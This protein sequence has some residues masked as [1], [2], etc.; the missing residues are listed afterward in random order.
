MAVCWSH[1]MSWVYVIVYKQSKSIWSCWVAIPEDPCFQ[2]ITG[3]TTSD[4]NLDLNELN[5]AINL[6]RIWQ[7]YFHEC[8]FVY[9]ATPESLIW[10][11]ILWELDEI[12]FIKLLM[13]KNACSDLPSKYGHNS[14]G[15]FSVMTVCSFILLSWSIC[16]C[17]GF[18]NMA[19]K[20]FIMTSMTCSGYRLLLNLKWIQISTFA[21]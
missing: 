8:G 17:Q 2:M 14:W 21:S 12:F 10:F 18:Y 20:S 1:P 15:V 9:V 7:S 4:W 3:F 16:M 5:S 6:R 13:S 19:A 11:I